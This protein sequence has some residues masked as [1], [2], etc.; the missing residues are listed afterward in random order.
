MKLKI[1]IEIRDTDV[2]HFMPTAQIVAT[3]AGGLPRLVSAPESVLCV[4]L[5]ELG[6]QLLNLRD[7]NIL[8]R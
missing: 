2:D 4:V 3:L 8:S 5:A 7:T 6:T 1:E